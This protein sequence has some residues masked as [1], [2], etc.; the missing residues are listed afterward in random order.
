MSNAEENNKSHMIFCGE[1]DIDYTQSNKYAF[2][3]WDF[4]NSL[5]GKNN[6]PQFIQD[7]FVMGNAYIGNAVLSLYSI[8]YSGNYC[9]TADVLIF[10]I[11]FELWHGVELWLKSS[12]DA[13]YYFLGINNK[14]KKSHKIYEYLEVLEEELKKLGMEQ[15]IDIALPEL[16]KLI[17]EFQRVN[18]NF[19]FARYSFNGKRTYQFYNAPLGEDEQWQKK[20]K[21]ED[22]RMHV[23]WISEMPIVPNTCVDLQELFV[24]ILDLVDNFRTFVKY[25]T[26]VIVEGGQLTDD[27]YNKYLKECEKVQK[28]MEEWDNNEGDMDM[29]AMM[30]FVYSHIL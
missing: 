25:L 18:A 4:D 24:I 12:V 28:N 2:L 10:P 19:D 1:K 14:I 5:G 22:E 21:S 23:D 29:K 17:K 8:L 30:K 16:I 11:M 3:N 27:A 6:V 13:I 20:E 7:N 26:L 15:T 9:S